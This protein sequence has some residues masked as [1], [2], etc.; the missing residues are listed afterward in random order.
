MSKLRFASGKLSLQLHVQVIDCASTIKALERSFNV[1]IYVYV[2][3]CTFVQRYSCT[4]HVHVYSSPTTF[5][6]NMYEST[7]VRKYNVYDHVRVRVYCVLKYF[8]TTV[9][10]QYFRTFVVS[11]GS[12]K[13]LYFRKYESNFIFEIDKTY[14][15]CTC[16]VV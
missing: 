2:Y 13:V 4:V 10:L 8:R 7:K 14:C 9:L 16:T 3:S 6:S 12:T 11:Y 1:R 5:M 15:T